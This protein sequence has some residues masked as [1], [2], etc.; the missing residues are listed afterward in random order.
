MNCYTTVIYQCGHKNMLTIRLYPR[1]HEEQRYTSR[2]GHCWWKSHL[3]PPGKQCN[4]S[5]A[6]P[7]IQPFVSIRYSNH[8]YLNKLKLIHQQT[9]KTP[10]KNKRTKKNP[11][12]REN[13]KW[14]SKWHVS[15]LYAD[16]SQDHAIID[17]LA[18][19]ENDGI[20]KTP[21]R[22]NSQSQSFSRARS[23]RCNSDE[24]EA[25]PE[26]EKED[27]A[28]SFLMSQQWDNETPENFSSVR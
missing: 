27:A 22:Q 4:F 6:F 21:I 18:D 16:G 7:N 13:N 10:N 28:L 3:E 24:E 8:L 19:L 15:L 23:Y 11:T 2:G 5:P 17:L 26:L 20:C 25:G 9:N 1:F 14:F 12:Q